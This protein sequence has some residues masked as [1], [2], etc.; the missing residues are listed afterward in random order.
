MNNVLRTHA[1]EFC[2]LY[3]LR[4]MWVAFF[5]LISLRSSQHKHP[6]LTKVKVMIPYNQVN[7]SDVTSKL[8][9]ILTCQGDIWCN[10]VHYGNL[11]V[12]YP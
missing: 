6:T 2:I 7:D 4:Q 11:R 3:Q 9:D 10:F 1:Y 12:T 8:S 5:V